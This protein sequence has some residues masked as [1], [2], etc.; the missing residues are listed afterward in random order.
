MRGMVNLLSRIVVYLFY[1]F[2]IYLPVP[3]LWS[4]NMD[5]G[6]EMKMKKHMK[7]A[8]FQKKLILPPPLPSVICFITVY[9]FSPRRYLVI[10]SLHD[11]WNF[12]IL[13]HT[14]WHLKFFTEE[15]DGTWR[16]DY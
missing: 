15:V 11:E 10:S 16:Y 14:L 2:A 3:W 12:I 4:M 5:M 6:M 8:C 13:C 1:H 7:D 9:F